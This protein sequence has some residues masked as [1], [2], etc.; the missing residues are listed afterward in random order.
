MK[1]TMVVLVLCAV[2]ATAGAQEWKTT[3]DLSYTSRYIWR[4]YDILDNAGAFQPSIDL[5]HENGLGATIWMSYPE[6]GGWTNNLADSRVNLTEYDYTLY[7]K[8]K[9]LA[10]DAW[11]TNYKLGWRYYDYIDTYT[12]AWDKQ[13]IFV[14]AEMPKLLD[15]GVVPH[16]AVY[17]LWPARSKASSNIKDASGTIYL[18]G[19][20][21]NLPTDLPL[22][23]S[24]DIVF[25]GGAMN[26]DH[27]WS[28]MVWGLKSQFKCPMT[29]A[30]I[31]PAVY[32][33]NSFE[34]SVNKSDEY[35]GT[36]SYS[37]AF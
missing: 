35:W 16:L 4:G 13:E 5:S 31:V 3:V 24:W 17:Q 9:A 37:F 7:Y 6:R 1:N 22:T 33:Q 26:S 28:H 23:F 29:G 18:M 14:E 20:D 15:N 2:A 10:G 8:G 36:I 30:K 19:F 25:N 12:K 32:F 34:D 21:Y 11:E 27:D